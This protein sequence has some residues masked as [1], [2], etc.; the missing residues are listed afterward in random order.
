M[1]ILATLIYWVIWVFNLLLIAH[2]VLSYFLDPYHPV[3]QWLSKIVE[4]VLAPIR[5][6]LPKNGPIDFSPVVLILALMVLNQILQ[7][8]LR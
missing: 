7:G 6:L 5:K 2:V 8:L 4:P 1:N 3:R